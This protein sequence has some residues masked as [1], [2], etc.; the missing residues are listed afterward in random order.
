MMERPSDVGGVIGHGGY[1]P[2]YLT[3]MAYYVEHDLALAIQINTTKMSETLN[4]AA[5]M[6]AL[7]KCAEA[8]VHR[9]EPADTGE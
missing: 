2:G 5:M 8:I 9:S 7:D 4:Y 6:E 1:F 3:N